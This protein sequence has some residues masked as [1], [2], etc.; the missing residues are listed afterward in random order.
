MLLPLSQSA[1][2]HRRCQLPE[3]CRVLPFLVL[4]LVGAGLSATILRGTVQQGSYWLRAHTTVGYFVLPS[5]GLALI[6]VGGS[7]TFFDLICGYIMG[8]KRGRWFLCGS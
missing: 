2:R 8:V 1:T 3:Q 4:L 7:T 6:M 5:I